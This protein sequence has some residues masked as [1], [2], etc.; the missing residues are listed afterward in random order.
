MYENKIQTVLD[1][2]E[3]NVKDDITCEALAALAGFSKSHFLRVFEAYVGYT[4][5]AY[6]RGRRLHLASHQVGHGDARITDIAFTYNFESHDVF[7]RAFKRAYGI[8]P[9]SYRR[10]RF[11]LPPFHAVILA[12]HTKG[13][14]AMDKQ[15]P[16]VSIM[17]KPA[18]M[19]IGIECRMEDGK[20][21][22]DLWKQY[23]DSWQCTFGS[24]AHLRVEPEKDMDYAL[25]VDR[26][27]SGYTYFIGIEVIS[28]DHIPAGTTGRMIPKTKYARFT[29]VGPV[30]ESM[31]RTY[32]Y[33]F[34]EWFP[35]MPYQTT[36]GPIMEHYDMRC[37]THIGIPPEQHEMD[38]YIPIEPVLTETKEVVEL[39]PYRAA[40]YKAV[41]RKGRKWHQ[42]KKE[43]FDVM[44]AWAKSQRFEL[45]E[46]RIRAHNNGGAAEEDFFY[47]VHIDITGK[48]VAASNDSRVSLVEREGGLFIA[49]PALHRMLEPTGQAFCR[50]FEQQSAYEMTGKWFEEFIVYD[51]K[52]KLDTV[53]RIHFGARRLA[54]ESL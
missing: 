52:V 39:L 23:F 22:P 24:I 31:G 43:A 51:G 25:T 38:I 4:V 53:I 44:V 14:E 8:T 42:V 41:G 47:E 50:W 48:E 33:I 45:S 7:G 54:G 11:L 12:Q 29:A 18:M 28:L 20:N 1:Y 34:K 9:E 3:A 5:M 17:T 27:E 13:T 46:L 36:A 49:M 19:L 10:K 32:D 21:S 37:A 16:K 40:Y 2:I 15:L 30:R 6:I 26:D 35:S